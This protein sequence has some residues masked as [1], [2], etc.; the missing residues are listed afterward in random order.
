MEISTHKTPGQAEISLMSTYPKL[1]WNPSPCEDSYRMM[2]HSEATLGQ[3]GRLEPW[4][5]S[6]AFDQRTGSR[7]PVSRKGNRGPFLK[8]LT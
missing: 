6:A 8:I 1:C 4:I 7:G 5:D 3:I 2:H